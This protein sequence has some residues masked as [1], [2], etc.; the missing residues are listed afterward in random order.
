MHHYDELMQAPREHA[1]RL[2]ELWR[3]LATRYRGLPRALVYE[4]L[5]EPTGKLTAEVLNP[6]LARTI[7]AIRVIDATRILIIE[8]ANWSSAKD[9]RDTLE[10]PKG[11]PNI[12]ASFHMYAPH[13]FT[14]QGAHW[15]PPSFGT[16]GIVFPGPP[17]TR[18]EPLPATA[19]SSEGA[20][21]FQR[22]DSEPSATN[23]SGPATVIEELD[24][25]KA[26]ADRTGLRV[27]LGEFGVIAHA[28]LASRERWTRLVRTEAERRGFGWAYWDYCQAFAAFT[29]CGAEGGWVPELKSALLD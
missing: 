4:I 14:H 7:A 28:D 21:F 22:Y 10:F 20:A 17:A 15:M 2:V 26:F 6:L 8:G 5:N 16:R 18:A 12:V 24:M 3:Q 1:D 29:P 19:E 11:D 9:L 23:P 27:H 25:A 13:Y